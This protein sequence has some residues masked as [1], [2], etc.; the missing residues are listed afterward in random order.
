MADEQKRVST[1]EMMREQREAHDAEMVRRDRHLCIH[2][3]L[4][5]IKLAT[6]MVA[7]I[8][9][10]FAGT[11]LLQGRWRVVPVVAGVGLVGLAKVIPA[12]RVRFATKASLALGGITLAGSSVVFT[13]VDK[14]QK[15][16][17]SA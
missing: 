12:S 9:G 3:T 5:V 4:D 1:A 16:E 14:I 7:G 17:E 8:G 11:H 2:G 10:G 15:E 13:F 6:A